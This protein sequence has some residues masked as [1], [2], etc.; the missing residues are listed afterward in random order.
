M[1][2]LIALGMLLIVVGF[3]VVLVGVIGSILS[4]GEPEA[5]GE[6]KAGGI[7]LIGPIPIVFGTDRTMVL[8]SICGGILLL[9]AYLA[10]RKG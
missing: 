5:I 2:K 9:M 10:W 1:Q 4:K 6:T 3:V 8:L 7:I